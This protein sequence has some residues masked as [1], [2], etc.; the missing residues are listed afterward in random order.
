MINQKVMNNHV[1][2]LYFD[3]KD[4]LLNIQKGQTPF[5]PCVGVLFELNDMLHY[6]DGQGVENRVNEVKDRADYFRSKI[7]HLPVHLPPF[8]LSNA[9]SPIRFEKEYA[10]EYRE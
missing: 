6:I 5:T 8:P 9:I 4:Y 7:S 1:Q 3:F 10:S 2:S